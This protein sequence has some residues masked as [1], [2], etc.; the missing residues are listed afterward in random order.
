M[1]VFAI[2]DDG[3][4][5]SEP[6]VEGE[7]WARGGCVAL[8]YWGD[9]ERTAKTFVRN[10]LEPNFTDPAYRTGDIVTLAEDR[11]NWRFV[12]RRDHMIKSRGYRIELGEIEA[13]LYSHTGV[14]E[15][16]VVALPDE[17]IGSRLKA[18]VVPV[19]PD[20]LSTPDLKAYCGQK[21]PS[22]MVPEL[23]EFRESLPK[24]STGK[25]NRREL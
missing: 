10:P 16:V 11:Q 20:Q 19:E 18:Y 14:K 21:L 6:G 3:R 8:G 2:D 7:L 1:E 13:A 12:G 23:F 17:L 22:Y 5:V 4:R 24:T 25:V 15:A 9:P